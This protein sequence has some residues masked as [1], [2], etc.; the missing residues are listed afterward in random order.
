MR[1]SAEVSDSPA[2][3]VSKKLIKVDVSVRV[4]PADALLRRSSVT[5]RLLALAHSLSCGCVRVYT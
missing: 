1:D 4:S 3:K 5:D 2:V